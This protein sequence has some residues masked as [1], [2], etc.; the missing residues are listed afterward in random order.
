M[1]TK[2]KTTSFAV[3]T[4][5]RA[6]CAAAE[7]P[8]PMVA[9]DPLM[10][11]IMSLQLTR[12]A[13]AVTGAVRIGSGQ[14]ITLNMADPLAPLKPTPGLVAKPAKTKARRKLP[15]ADAQLKKISKDEQRR[16]DWAGR[17]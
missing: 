2:L 7:V 1:G 4:L 6:L 10:N 13:G 15:H 14:V 17:K 8:A 16:A 3:V 5:L 9:H 12:P 11:Q